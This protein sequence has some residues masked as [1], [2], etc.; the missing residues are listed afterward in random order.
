ML[1]QAAIVGILVL[2]YGCSSTPRPEVNASCP[3]SGFADVSRITEPA[4]YVD[5]AKIQLQ[6]PSMNAPR[7]V[8]VWAIP[9]SLNGV[10]T[11]ASLD[12]Y[13]SKTGEV[14]AA[15]DATG[16]QRLA[17]AVQHGTKS[18]RFTPPPT[19]FILPV[20][21]NLSW[22]RSD[23][24]PYHP[25]FNPVDDTGTSPAFLHEAGPFPDFSYRLTVAA[26]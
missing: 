9:R 12:L 3:A 22:Q 6:Y 19:P 16:D 1:K 4:R 20:T 26:R 18:W 14:V 21:F 17:Q 23:S 11:A 5:E 8:R 15:C 10:D 25:T 7:G 13:I 24:G 2:A